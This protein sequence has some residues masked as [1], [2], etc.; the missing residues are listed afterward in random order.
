MDELTVVTVPHSATARVDSATAAVHAWT[1]RYSPQHKRYY[2][3]RRSPTPETSWT[4]ADAP[5]EWNCSEQERTLVAATLGIPHAAAGVGGKTPLHVLERLR[6]SS[7]SP[8][9]ESPFANGSPASGVDR[10]PPHKSTS[11]PRRPETPGE[12]ERSALYAALQAIQ[13]ARDELARQGVIDAYAAKQQLSIAHDVKKALERRSAAELAALTKQYNAEIEA[14]DAEV[15]CFTAHRAVLA[16]DR[17]EIDIVRAE[18]AADV[19]EAR[20]SAA[21]SVAA[22]RASAAASTA[23]AQQATRNGIARAREVHIEELFEMRTHFKAEAEARAEA[24]ERAIA[25]MVEDYSSL[26]DSHAQV[27]SR[28]NETEDA[29]RRSVEDDV[30]KLTASHEAKLEAE[31]TAHAKSRASDARRHRAAQHVRSDQKEEIAAQSAEIEQLKAAARAVLEEHA[32]LKAEL[33]EREAQLKAG[34]NEREAQLHAEFHSK[35]AE[36]QVSHETEVSEAVAKLEVQLHAEFYSKRAEL[37]LS[38]ETQVSEAVAKL[39]REHAIGL[40]QMQSQMEVSYAEMQ[41]VHENHAEHIGAQLLNREQA[42]AKHEEDAAML[43]R[44]MADDLDRAK[45]TVTD[46]YRD[47]MAELEVCTVHPSCIRSVWIPSR[48]S[49]HVPS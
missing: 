47:R 36:L 11:S 25:R 42:V 5:R 8:S 19:A 4:C 39:E 32:I 9:A 37:K 7:R 6:A 38:H 17:A 26:E 33:N 29:H 23:A 20:S 27:Q 43:R 30:A 49:S 15:A 40:D 18:A 3:E 16:A 21:T 31:A 48:T 28:R 34:L 1:P 44:T 13:V 22:A 45:L 41:R 10:T 2:F 14:H 12:G 46:S 35:H 24:H